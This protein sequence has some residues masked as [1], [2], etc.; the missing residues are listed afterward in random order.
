MKAKL[1]TYLR[2]K[3]WKTIRCKPGRC[4]GEYSIIDLYRDQVDFFCPPHEMYSEGSLTL[5]HRINV[6]KTLNGV[7]FL[8]KMALNDWNMAFNRISI[9]RSHCCNEDE[10]PVDF[11]EIVDDLVPHLPPH[12][13]G[14]AKYVFSHS[15][16][17]QLAISRIFD[18]SLPI[19]RSLMLLM[20]T[21]TLLVKTNGKSFE[22][23]F[24]RHS[25]FA[26]I[27]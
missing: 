2:Q 1:K 27:F 24:F 26:Q 8:P 22:Q 17:L 19:I 5:K 16:R 11:A 25:V 20:I 21:D 18:L 4:P 10:S 13:I 12:S 23:F 6:T 3:S 15:K 9:F 14:G 7:T